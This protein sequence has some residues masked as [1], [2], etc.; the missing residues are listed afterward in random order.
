MS[1]CASAVSGRSV[2]LTDRP[3]VG[4]STSW[5]C[6]CNPGIPK[7]VP[8]RRRRRGSPGRRRRATA[9]VRLPAR[10]AGAREGS[11]RASARAPRRARDGA[12]AASAGRPG[13]P[14]AARSSSATHCYRGCA[15]AAPARD[16]LAGW[17]HE[18]ARWGVE[19]M[20]DRSAAIESARRPLFDASRRARSGRRGVDLRY[21][22]RSRAD[23]EEASSASFE[24]AL[25]SDLERGF[26]TLGPHRDDWSIEA[27]GLDL[28]RYGSQG[29]QRLG[30]AGAAAGG[31]RRSRES[32]RRARRCCCSTTF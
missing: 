7:R 25:E 27:D 8:G 26:T 12:V 28:R 29:Q 19:L 24:S 11:G 22:P 14:T 3:T 9:R 6:C 1:W 23:S 13:P 17:D 30:A 4:P 31:A 5:R 16:S 10:P 18:L 15:R 2:K 21:R 32:P 20:A